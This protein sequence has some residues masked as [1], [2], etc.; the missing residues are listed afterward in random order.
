MA[1][2]LDYEEAKTEKEK[3]LAALAC[4]RAKSAK[5][6]A[7]SWAETA[8]RHAEACGIENAVELLGSG[9]WPELDALRAALTAKGRS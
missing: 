4:S 1:H 5:S 9:R 2:L 7:W 6:G 3:G 8:A